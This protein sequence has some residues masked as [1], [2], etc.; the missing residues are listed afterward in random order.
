[1][2]RIAGSLYHRG[3]HRLLGNRLIGS[4][5]AFLTLLILIRIAVNLYLAIDLSNKGTSL[6]AVQIAS[7]QFVFL[8]AYIVWI[9]TIASYRIGFALPRLCFINLTPHGDRFRFYFLRKAALQRPT[10]LAF[11][12]IMLLN[13]LI[14][15]MICDKG[16][17]VVARGVAALVFSIL[18]IAIVIAVAVWSDPS[19]SEIQIL[20]MLYLLLLV[21][22]NPDIG[23]FRDRVV[24]FFWRQHFPFSSVWVIGI[25]VGLIVSLAVF[26]LVMGRIFVAVSTSFRR[27]LSLSPIERWYWRFL[28]VRTWFILYAIITPILISTFLSPVT[29][30]WALIY[31][32]LF[33]VVSYLIFIAHCENTLH[34]SWR[35][36]L[37]DAHNFR[38]IAKSALVHILLM[39]IP[40]LGYIIAR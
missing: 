39:M 15:A 14:L 31:F 10:N 29:K 24:I 26:V 25:T 22:L 18:G 11:V 3:T 8:S 40:V 21:A 4:L 12:I 7:A 1:M 5:T 37:F 23:S 33:G 38:L 27:S 6:D 28:R 19:R 13:A 16:H 32:V 2:K 35:C 9:G 17:E 30:L 20:E 36:S 34:D